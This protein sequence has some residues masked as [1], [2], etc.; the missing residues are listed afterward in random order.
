M[1]RRGAKKRPASA[2]RSGHAGVGAKRG[3]SSWDGGRPGDGPAAA[4]VEHNTARRTAPLA[5][6][7]AA[8]P[9]NWAR[10]QTRIRRAAR[11]SCKDRAAEL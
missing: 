7:Q 8:L 2:C 5:S 3:G 4:C 9:E 1:R 10:A 6:C 11:G